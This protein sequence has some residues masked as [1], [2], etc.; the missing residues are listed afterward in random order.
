VVGTL[1]TERRSELAGQIEAI[2]L[3]GGFLDLQVGDLATRLRCSRSTLYKLAP[4]KD[5]LI[6]ATL[7]GIHERA[8]AEALRVA[9]L[10]ERPSERVVAYLDA[11][12]IHQRMGSMKYL[13]DSM[14]WPPSKALF[15]QTMVA[16]SAMLG[17]FIE[18]GVRSGDLAPV[19][20]AFAAHLV[21][22]G[23]G[24]V[25]DPHVLMACG[26]TGEQALLEARAFL[27]GAL[28]CDVRPPETPRAVMSGK[29]PRTREEQL[30]EELRE[31]VLH[32]GFR[33]LRVGELA[34]R[35]R[36][37]RS[38][39]YKLAPTKDALVLQV[40]GASI[41]RLEEAALRATDRAAG[42]VAA[43]AT[44]IRTTLRFQQVGSA[45][46]WADA[47][48]WEPA[49]T[50]L[51]ARMQDGVG[52]LAA[53]IQRGVDTGEFRPLNAKFAASMI[54]A[55]VTANAD[56]GLLRRAGLDAPKPIESFMRFVLGGLVC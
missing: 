52:D 48:A 22:L 34:G 40:I 45:E 12:S 42:P 3:E 19:N 5:E 13:Q 14:A 10:R 29:R 30:L 23:G 17:R 43:V 32:E 16:A 8:A 47:G 27:S 46:F 39:L 1:E 9:M 38:T 6:L 37:S 25:R 54:F 53:I 24:A 7:R 41:D 44:Y 28:S 35:L 56:P 15:D 4:G 2:V 49:L 26:L 21:L 31:I 33:D 18:D 11:L 51:L 20:S 50:L 36:C 55:C